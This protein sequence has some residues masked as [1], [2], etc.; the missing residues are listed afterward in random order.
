M[1]ATDL[2][3]RQDLKD[4]L[5]ITDT[6]FDSQ[7]D[8]LITAMSL[9]M[10]RYCN[11]DFVQQAN[12]EVRDGNG[13]SRMLLKQ[14]PVASVTSVTVDGIAIPARTVPT[15][16][17]FVAP[18]PG[19]NAGMLMLY[20]YCFAKGFQNV[21]VVYT[22]GLFANTAAATATEIGWACRELC[23]W[24]WKRRQRPDEMSR[25][26]GGAEVASFSPKD[27]PPEVATTLS[28]YLNPAIPLG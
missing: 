25:S 21:T 7:F 2:T 27:M 17:G 9:F 22:A 23:A 3:T 4:W 18:D 10:A 19:D 1:A 5:S 13:R 15:G 26:L 20:G 12:T 24:H 6:G 16:S 11:R 28:Q 14:Y 8:A